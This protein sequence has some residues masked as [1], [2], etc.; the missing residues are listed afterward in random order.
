MLNAKYQGHTNCNQI[1]ITVINK[2]KSDIEDSL[3]MAKPCR[4]HHVYVVHYLYNMQYQIKSSNHKK[5]LGQIDEAEEI[6]ISHGEKIIS[7]KI[8]KE[9]IILTEQ[10]V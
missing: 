10:I 5:K 2:T 8:R 7:H 4:L 1:Q 3:K 6:T 9:K